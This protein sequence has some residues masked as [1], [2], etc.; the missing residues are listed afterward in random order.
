MRG[1]D[2][3]KAVNYAST[4]T[5]DQQRL[6]WWRTC[7]VALSLG[8]FMVTGGW[9]LLVRPNL[10]SGPTGVTIRAALFVVRYLIFW[11]WYG[12]SFA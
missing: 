7:R 12:F 2:Q 5:N 8:F 10:N 11:G 1:A 6:T 4:V 9:L 3:E